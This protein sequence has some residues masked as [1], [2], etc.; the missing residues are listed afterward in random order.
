MGKAIAVF[1]GRNGDTCS[2]YQPGKVAIYQREEEKWQVV[3]ARDFDLEQCSG[4]LGLRQRIWELLTFMEDCRI[5][6]A[7][8]ITGIPYYE[9]E[10]ANC[11]LWEIDGNP[12][13]FLDFILDKEEADQ[14][15]R[16]DNP[17]LIPIEVSPG[18]Y[19]ISLQSIQEKHAGFTSKQ[20]LR[21]FL[22]RG[23]YKVLEVYCSHVPPWLELD[24]AAQNLEWEIKQL[25][26]MEYKIAITKKSR[27]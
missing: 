13:Q 15:I 19:R 24:L 1:L 17:L 20:V 3:R 26:E 22:R 12:L 4:M 6:V 16:E 11:S 5:F 14:E 10:K 25:G 27:G 21:P 23:D 9:L 7:K 2:I 18:Q 8:S